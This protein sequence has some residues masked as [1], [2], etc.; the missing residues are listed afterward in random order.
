MGLLKRIFIKLSNTFDRASKGSNGQT[1]EIVGIVGAMGGGAA[2]GRT[3]TPWK[4]VFN[5]VAWRE[6]GRPINF[7][8]LWIEQFLGYDDD[9]CNRWVDEPLARSTI[10]MLVTFED[11]E[12]AQ[13]PTAQMMRFLGVA[14]DP[15]LEAATHELLNPPDFVDSVLGRFK[16]DDGLVDIFRKSQEWQ[17]SEIELSL[18][19]NNQADLS[20]AASVAR[21]LIENQS[22]WHE[23]ARER[24]QED[25][26]ELWLDVWREE[27]PF[28]SETEFV[29]LTRLNSIWVEND[30]T[31]IFEF[32]D[33]DLFCGHN[34]S[35]GGDLQNG[36]ETA[37][38]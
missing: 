15:D 33:G 18:V 6:V 4:G 1:L 25:L 30:G 28:L 29:T 23:K 21:L 20:K 22:A 9:A 19:G 10:R 12:V 16:A 14:S 31:F 38:I 5:L 11:K 24:I 17:G 36:F 2:R 3:G 34:I 26:Y 32:D 35:A 8:E 27:K 7:E 13:R 37:T